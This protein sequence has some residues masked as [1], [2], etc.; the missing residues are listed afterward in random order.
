MSAYFLARFIEGTSFS[1]MTWFL[2]GVGCESSVEML[3]AVEDHRAPHVPLT[4]L[5]I[6][7]WEFFSELSRVG[8]CD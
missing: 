7:H 3:Q 2:R 5:T 6:V 8:G 4:P 1:D